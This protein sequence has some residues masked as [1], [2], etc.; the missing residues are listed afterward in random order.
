MF[1]YDVYSKPFSLIPAFVL[2]NNPA[3]PKTKKL[4]AE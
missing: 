3:K 2:K 4:I 1:A